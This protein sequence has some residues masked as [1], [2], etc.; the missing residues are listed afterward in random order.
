[1]IFISFKCPS[2]FDDVSRVFRFAEAAKLE[3]R[4]AFDIKNES[5][6]GND[7]ACI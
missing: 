3:E 4:F 7:E 1:L 5:L 2:K 6:L